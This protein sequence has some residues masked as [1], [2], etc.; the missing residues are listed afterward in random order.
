[1][2]VLY[3]FFFD[4]REKRKERKRYFDI[5]MEQLYYFRNNAFLL[6]KRTKTVTHIAIII[7]LPLTSIMNN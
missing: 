5:F 4:K 1:M 3:H 6:S 7:H 2:D